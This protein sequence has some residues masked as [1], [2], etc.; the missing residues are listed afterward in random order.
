MVPTEQTPSDLEQR[1]L[2]AEAALE[3]A[4][5]ERNRLWE[6]LN[7]VKAGQRA[8]N[9]YR[10]LYEQVVTSASWKLTRP[11]RTVKWFVREVPKRALRLLS[12]R[13]R[14]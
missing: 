11:L 3:E 13:P 4:V 2:A 14:S 1:T 6:E 10:F 8:E 12:N 5:A 9:Y 7:R